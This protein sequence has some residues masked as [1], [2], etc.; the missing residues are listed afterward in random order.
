MTRSLLT[1]GFEDIDSREPARDCR[2]CIEL[3][4]AETGFTAP[5]TKDCLFAVALLRLVVLGGAIESLPAVLSLDLVLES[6]VRAVVAGVPVRGV[7]PVELAMEGLGLVGDF[8]GDCES[9]V[10]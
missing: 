3:G 7:E 10:S 9:R 6:D 1:R 8:V 5:P 4:L 2:V